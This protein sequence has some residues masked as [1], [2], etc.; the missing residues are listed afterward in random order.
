VPDEQVYGVGEGSAA[1]IAESY[2]KLLQTHPSIDNSGAIPSFDMM[3]LG[4]GGDGHCGCLFPDSAEIKATGTGAVV[5]AGNDER[6]DG[7]FVAISMDVMNAAKVVLISAAGSG[8]ASMVAKALSGN[9]GPYDCPAGM[10][11]AQGQ[12]LWFTDADG[13]AEFDEQVEDDDEDEE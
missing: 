5:L 8:R 9:F 11:E 2:T 1:E 12:T 13:I 3:L 4:T 7:D 10:V 6:A